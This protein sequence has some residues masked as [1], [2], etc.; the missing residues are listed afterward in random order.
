MKAA[1]PI[2][3]PRVVWQHFFDLV[4]IPRPSKNEGK[5]VDFI[6]AWAK[7]R[8]FQFAR[9]KVNNICVHVPASS[10][11]VASGNVASGSARRPVLFQCH[12]DIVS[13]TDDRDGVGADASAGK[14]PMV[15]G[16][17]D[18]ANEKWLVANDQ[19]DWINSPY[20]TLGADNGIGVAMMMALAEEPNRKQPLE[21]LFTVDEEAGMT[22]AF[23]L[24][25]DVLGITSRRLINI[26]TEDDDE[27]TIGAAGGKDVEV[28]LE[29]LRV[30]ASAEFVGEEYAVLNITLDGL[31]GGHSGIEINQGRGNANRLLA[32]LLSAIAASTSLYVV[33]WKGGS[34]RNAIPDCSAATIAVA[35]K[36]VPQVQQIAND[37]VAQADRLFANRDNPIRCS[38]E[39][40][41][42]QPCQVLCAESSLALIRLLQSLPTGI[43]EMTPELPVLVESSCNMAI[44]DLQEGGIAKIHCSV[45]GTTQEALADVAQSIEAIAA[46]AG[47]SVR[48]SDG[49]PGWKP[50]LN[51]QL[52]QDAERSYEALFGAKAKVHAVHAGLECGLLATKLP[53]L[54]AISIGPTIKGNHAVGERVSIASVAKSYQFVLAILD[55]LRN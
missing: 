33:R 16:D 12:L 42:S 13:V 24:E 51:S 31:K 8:G 7:A 30:D 18:P 32:R 50:D 20:T 36:M 49:Y 47:G 3:E 46:L 21:L 38:I 45:R 26:D 5:A 48:I 10:G 9:D 29:G 22:G 41:P 1:F 40:V 17:F 35:K 52:L 39:E 2:P 34:R 11:N 44:V 14:I 4:A 15:R 53:G 25:P 23:G 28:S 43:C 19:G 27:I 6:E 55:N 54:E 37:F